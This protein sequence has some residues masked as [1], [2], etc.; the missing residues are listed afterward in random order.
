[1]SNCMSD[2]YLTVFVHS[3]SLHYLKVTNLEKGL[4]SAYLAQ[5]GHTSLKEK[6]FPAIS[7][8]CASL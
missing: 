6:R 8:F 2:V 5:P 1:M 7:T 4:G 3:L